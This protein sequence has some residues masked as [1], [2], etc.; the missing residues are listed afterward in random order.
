M[1]LFFWVHASFPYNNVTMVLWYPYKIQTTQTNLPSLGMK[2][3]IWLG[4]HMVEWTTN[5][6][7]FV[8]NRDHRTCWRDM[9]RDI[10][11]VIRLK[12]PEAL[13]EF[14]T[15]CPT[16]ISQVLCFIKYWV[17]NYED[18]TYSA[19]P[20]FSNSTVSQFPWFYCPV[21]PVVGKLVP[22]S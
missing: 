18:A 13:V 6:N 19:Y 4:Q 9:F 1:Y 16:T 14:P 8:R 21:Y 20:F 11:D 15:T 3:I 22:F 17:M 10:F 7:E 2:M 12:T 5:H